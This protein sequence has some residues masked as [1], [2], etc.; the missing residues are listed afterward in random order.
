MLRLNALSRSVPVDAKFEKYCRK[1]N[2]SFIVPELSDM[3]KYRIIVTTCCNAAVISGIGVPGGHFTHVFI[4]EA[5]QALE[6]EAMIPINSFN[7]PATTRFILAGDHKQLGPIIHSRYARNL[8]LGISLLE[9]VMGYSTIDEPTYP[10]KMYDL[11]HPLK[12][13]SQEGFK[14]V[15]SLICVKLLRNYRSHQSILNIPNSLFYKG[16]LEAH[17]D[18]VVV[19]SLLGWELLR[20][21]KHPILFMHTMGID[22]RDGDSP[23]WFNITEIQRVKQVVQ[24][25]RDF[26]VTSDQIGVITPYNKQASSLRK[27]L[28]DVQVGTVETFQGNLNINA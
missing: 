11:H 22:Q 7:H 10:S 13:K 27:V 25:L 2:G 3:L 12:L 19:E 5:G 6:P 14:D 24:S 16:E 17:A 23:S 15:T 28:S 8:G 21:R 20:N 26:R 18:K 1:A 4:D 9:R